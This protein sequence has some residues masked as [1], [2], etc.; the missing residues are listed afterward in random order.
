MYD[1]KKK[2]YYSTLKIGNIYRIYYDE[3]HFLGRVID[4]YI[5]M[6]GTTYSIQIISTENWPVIKEGEV[7]RL[8]RK[9]N[10]HRQLMFFIPIYKEIII[11]AL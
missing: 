3:Y 10:D 11:E 7:V 6:Q 2:V 5:D 1:N 9:D 4:K 8:N